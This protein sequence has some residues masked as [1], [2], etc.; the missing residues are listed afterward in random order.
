MQIKTI[1]RYHL[2]PFRLAIIK[3]STNN[4]CWRGCGEKGT[5]LHCWCVCKLV[6]PLWRTIWKVKVAQLCPTLYNP[7]DYIQ[8]MEFSMPEYWGGWPFPSPDLPNPGIEPRSLALQAHSFPTELSGKPHMEV[9]YKT[10]TV[11]TWSCNLIPWLIYGKN[12]NLKK[13]RHSNVHSSIIYNSHD[14]AET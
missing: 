1:I 10:K 8:S 6:Q 5:P 11:T 9:P 13:Y 2:S 3:K 14:T 7:T 4:K 12:S